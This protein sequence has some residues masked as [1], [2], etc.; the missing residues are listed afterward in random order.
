MTDLGNLKALATSSPG[1]TPGEPRNWTK[2]ST[3]P[4]DRL[5]PTLW[6]PVYSKMEGEL[7]EDGTCL[8]KV[9]RRAR[10]ERKRTLWPSRR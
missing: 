4:P 8:W 3:R 2:A 6:A 5:E 1:S 9:L 7:E 10:A